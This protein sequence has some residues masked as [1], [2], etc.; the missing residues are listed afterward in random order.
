M[1]VRSADLMTNTILSSPTL[2]DDLKA[3]PE[4]TLRQQATIAKAGT[5]L[6]TDPV[7]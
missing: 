3:N 2:I 7:I 4:P 6:D 1:P 5:P